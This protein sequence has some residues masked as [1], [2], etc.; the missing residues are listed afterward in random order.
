MRRLL[1]PLTRVA[2]REP[3][4][5][6]AS[7]MTL[8]RRWAACATGDDPAQCAAI[9]R[10]PFA[11]SSVYVADRGPR[12][13][14]A[15]LRAGGRHGRDAAVR[16]LRRRGLARAP[17]ATAFVHRDV[18]FSVQILRYAPIGTAVRRRR[19]RARG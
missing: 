16:R 2:G 3:E 13:R 7:H 4:H 10:Q 14:P 5:G 15:R 11:A 12:G 9:P 6:A 19:P 18:R 1:G 17:D 8:M